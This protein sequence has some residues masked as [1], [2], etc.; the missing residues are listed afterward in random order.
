MRLRFTSLLVLVGIALLGLGCVFVL[1]MF[2]RPSLEGHLVL[3]TGGSD[4]AYRELA[5]TYEHEL[6]N[7]GVTL[8]LKD[9]LQGADLLKALR[10]DKSGVQGGIIKGGLMSSLTGRLA[11]GRARDFHEAEVGAARSLGRL[12]YEPIWVFSRATLPIES[13]RDL[14]GKRILTGLRQS[15]SRRIAIQLLR[16]NGVNKDNSAFV[17]EELDADGHALLAGEADA[18]IV[19]LPPEAERIQKLLRVAGIRLMNFNAEAEAY[20]TRFPALSKV[21]LY[22]GSVEFQPVVPTADI[23]LLVT[24]AALIVR[25]DLHPALANLLAHAVVHNP[26]SPFDQS[27][28]PIL[29]HRAGHFPSIDDPEYEVSKEARLVY[30]TGELPFLL[31]HLAPLNHAIGLP[32][33]FTASVNAYGVQV[34]LFLIPALTILLPLMRTIPL[35]YRWAVRQRLLH[36]YHELKMVERDLDATRSADADAGRLMAEIERIDAAVRRIRVPLEFSDQLYDLRGH[37][38][39]VQRRVSQ[40]ASPV[41]LAAA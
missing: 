5:T 19:I 24:S 25:Q 34:L 35:L 3:A 20:T 28:D 31:R 16:A 13:L 40:R 2:M 29:F 1:L 33:A 12:F 38:E 26:K 21:V 39:L 18:A 27:G 14:Q 36:W 11:S 37:I 6:A 9:D 8:E 7:S 23:T 30:K 22:R 41:Q 17:E 32:F 4:G 10:D 15:G